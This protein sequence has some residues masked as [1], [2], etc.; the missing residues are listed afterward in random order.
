MLLAKFSV[1]G[2]LTEQLALGR[3]QGST[4]GNMPGINWQKPSGIQ[5]EPQKNQIS[6]SEII[7]NQYS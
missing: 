2:N 7:H 4:Q 3:V 1:D 6:L 5:G